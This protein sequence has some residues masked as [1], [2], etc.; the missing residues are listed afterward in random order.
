M[1]SAEEHTGS[2][3]CGDVRY[4]VTGPLRDIIACHCT[5][6][7]RTTGHYLTA[8]AVRMKNFHLT[9]CAGLKW[10]RATPTARRGFCRSCGSSL[11]WAPESDTH[12]S[13]VTAS[14]DDTSGLKLAAHIFVGAKGS[15]YELDPDIPVFE[16]NSQGT[17]PFPD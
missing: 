1:G 15:Y 16:G 4:R 11:F 2:C 6:C 10:Y 3:L 17:V 8:T 9:E 13:I 12:I 5:Q 7:R 14:L